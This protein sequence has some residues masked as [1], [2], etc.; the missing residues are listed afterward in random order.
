[1][2]KQN[3]KMSVILYA[4]SGARFGAIF[5]KEKQL[6]LSSRCSKMQ[7]RTNRNKVEQ[8][9]Q[10]GSSPPPATK[11]KPVFSRRSWLFYL[12]WCPFGA[13]MPSI[14]SEIRLEAVEASEKMCVYVLRV[15]SMEEC[16]R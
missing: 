14:R 12:F 5:S 16:P 13:T 7:S 1:M 10:K 9:A 2:L 6:K 4:Y 11:A 8:T 15:M 3:Q